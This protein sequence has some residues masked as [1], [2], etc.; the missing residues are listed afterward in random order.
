MIIEKL[1]ECPPKNGSL[2]KV[3]EMG[4][5]V[6]LQYMSRRNSKQT[7]QM[8]PGMENYVELSTGEVK[9]VKK[10][11]TRASQEKSLARTFATVRGLINTNVTDV[12]KVRWITLTYAENMTDT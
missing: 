7:I 11:D 10:N 9:P 1:A 4:N 2:L 5:I 12:S 6:E 8:L 3:T